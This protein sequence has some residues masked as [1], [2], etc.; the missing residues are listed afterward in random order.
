MRTALAVSTVLLLCAC[1]STVT[2]DLVT[3]PPAEA[4][5]EV[6]V[7]IEGLDFETSDGAVETLR[8]DEVQQVN[9]LDLQ[10]GNS[11]RIA[12]GESLPEGRYRGVRLR[13]DDTEA[14]VVRADGGELVLR[15]GAVEDFA[16][17]EFTLDDN[18]SDDTAL[19]LALDLRLS[20]R[21]SDEADDEN[22]LTLQPR[23][24]AVLDNQ[25]AAVEGLVPTGRVESSACTQDVDPGVG[26]GVAVYLFDGQDVEPDDADENAP[27]PLATTEVVNGAAGWS[28]RLDWLTAGDYTLALAC[29]AQAENPED[30]ED[31]GDED[32]ELNFVEQQNIQ[33]DHEELLQADFES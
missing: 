5:L 14:R 23:A 10:G 12:D 8:L 30:D 19:T 33:L 22:D 27:E 31:S 4:L 7:G 11:L 28:Y 15:L 24:R 16:P 32:V 2:V 26:V 6:S 1:E 21:D 29:G 25:A 9:L 17:L 18:D 20:L 3:D 13:L